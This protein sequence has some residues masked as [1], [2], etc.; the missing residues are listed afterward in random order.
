MTRKRKMPKLP[1][2]LAGDSERMEAA[3]AWCEGEGLPVRRSTPF[4]LLVGPLN[5]FPDSGKFYIGGSKPLEER[6]LRAFKEAVAAWLAEER[7]EYR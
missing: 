2:R 3:I 1:L 4:H 5:F 7:R 6:G